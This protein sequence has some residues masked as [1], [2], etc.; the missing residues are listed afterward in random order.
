MAAYKNRLQRCPFLKIPK[1]I[2][3]SLSG[4]TAVAKFTLAQMTIDRMIM[5]TPYYYRPRN[6]EDL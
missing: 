6:E 4:A 1:H 3:E 2:D 5:P